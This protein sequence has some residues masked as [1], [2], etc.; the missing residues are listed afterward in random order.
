MSAMRIDHVT[1]AAPALDPLR[2]VF[3]ELGLTTDYGGEHGNGVTHMALL[4]FD[5][6]SYIELIAA[7]TPGTP[8]PWWNKFIV[9]DGGPCAWAVG[10]DDVAAEAERITALG[11]KV[12][13]PNH[14]GRQKPDGTKI[15]WDSA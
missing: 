7:I 5:D 13:G 9:Q 10:I 14:A 4:G 6:G 15:E 1:L 3:A 2:G 8:S 11:I 12:N